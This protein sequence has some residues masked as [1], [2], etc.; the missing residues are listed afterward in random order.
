MNQPDFL[1]DYETVLKRIEAIN[2]IKYQ[3][4]RN[5]IN[6]AVTYLSPFITH[7]II[8]TKQIADVVLQKYSI[9]DS[10]KLLQ[11]LGWREFFHRVWE[12]KGDAIFS[13]LRYEQSKVSAMEMPPA[14]LEANTG[15]LA[16][17]ESIKHLYETGYMHNHARMWV[18][19]VTCNVGEFQW[20]DPA[21]WLYYHLLDGD[22]ASNMLSWQ[23]I[24]G[25]FSHKKYYANQDNLNK[26]FPQ[27]QSG[28]FLDVSYDA[29]DQMEVPEV[30]NKWDY[31]QPQNEF[32]ASDKFEFDKNKP[33]LLHHIWNLD[34][35]WQAG[36]DAQRILLIEPSRFERFPLSPK[37]WEFVRHWARQIEGLKVF[38][39]EW[40]ELFPVDY[41]TNLIIAKDY[42]GI[43]DWNCSKVPRDWLYENT[44]GYFKNF[45]SFWKE[46]ERELPAR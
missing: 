8:S 26:Y 14:I 4:T 11:E 32:P 44:K 6:G 39:G 25:S 9:K 19:S 7:G 33:T 16:I 37:R 24:V 43:N 13:D 34:P 23:W 28:T 10:L 29:F 17:D 30:L 27:K 36:S 20:C 2:P 21:G 42:T 31:F 1:V 22:L 3:R 18:A 12:D 15:I 38:V 45:F 35:N 46:A 40:D 5:D 41:D